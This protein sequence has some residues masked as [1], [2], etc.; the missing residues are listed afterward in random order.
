MK[1]HYGRTIDYMRISI[2]DRCNLQC[3]YCMP[4]TIPH[5]PKEHLL[6]YEEIQFICQIA[7]DIG[8]TK[9]KITGGEPLVRSGCPQLIGKLKT[10][11]EITQVTMTTNGINLEQHLHELKE[12]GL[13]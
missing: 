2:T 8:I 12:N 9:L 10:I 1:D 3:R 13:D 5:L 11:P 7:A 4:H 6:P